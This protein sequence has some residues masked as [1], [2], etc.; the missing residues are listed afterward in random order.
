MA[1]YRYFKCNVLGGFRLSDLNKNIKQGEYLQLDAQMADNS[2]AVIAAIRS[3]W[4]VE[5]GEKEAGKSIHIESSKVETPKKPSNESVSKTGVAIHDA[6]ETNRPLEVRQ[7]ERKRGRP[8]RKSDVQKASATV[9]LPDFQKVAEK[10]KGNG[11]DSI[12]K[13]DRTLES[14]VTAKKTVDLVKEDDDDEFETLRV[15]IEEPESQTA[16]EPT[17][18]AVDLI[19]EEP[20]ILETASSIKEGIK[21]EVAKRATFRRKND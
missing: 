21:A 15:A 14:P 12:D 16:E 20:E 19:E 5:V 8:P 13:K 11:D 10:R 4:M 1:E 3:K 9:S 17:V 7:A 6:S 2:R 18:E